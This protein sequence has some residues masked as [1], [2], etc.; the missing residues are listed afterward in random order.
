MTSKKISLD[1]QARSKHF[2]YLNI[3]VGGIRTRDW[4]LKLQ[5]KDLTLRIRERMTL[6]VNVNDSNKW[7]LGHF[8]TRSR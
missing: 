4:R 8:T 2:N 7:Q 3:A 6:I 1:D 5:N